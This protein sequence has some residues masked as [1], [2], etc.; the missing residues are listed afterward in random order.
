MT[1]GTPSGGG[2]ADRRAHVRLDVVGRL[3]GTLD[4]AATGQLLNIGQGGALVASPV[5][6]PSH[7]V[8]TITLRWSGY[9]F[10]IDTRVRHVYETLG[11]A[12]PLMFEVGLEFLDAPETLL[13][14]LADA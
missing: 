3:R 4:T 8:H 5:Q 11:A 9:D 2:A 13:A 14:L 6:L 1:G 10:R 12:G 7:A